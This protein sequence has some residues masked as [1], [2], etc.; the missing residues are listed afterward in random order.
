MFLSPLF[1]TSRGSSNRLLLLLSPSNGG[2]KYNYDAN[3]D[4]KLAA[5]QP[6]GRKWEWKIT[7]HHPSNSLDKNQIVIIIIII[8]MTIFVMD[9]NTGMCEHVREYVREYVFERVVFFWEGEKC[10]EGEDERGC[11]YRKIFLFLSFTKSCQIIT[12]KYPHFT[13]K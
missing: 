3:T 13:I 4:K 7:A 9:V 5:A 12:Y 10:I 1:L 2:W 6:G 8:I 11:K